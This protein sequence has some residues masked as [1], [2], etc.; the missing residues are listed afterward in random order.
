M[1]AKDLMFRLYKVFREI[2]MMSDKFEASS[3]SWKLIGRYWSWNE[4]VKTIIRVT[5]IL[6]SLM[7]C[8]FSASNALRAESKSIDRKL[9]YCVEVEVNLN[10]YRIMKDPKELFYELLVTRSFISVNKA[11]PSLLD[12]WYFSPNGKKLRAKIAGSALWND[13]TKLSARDAAFAI[14]KGLTFRPLGKKIRVKGTEQINDPGWISKTYEGIKIVS[15]DIF[16][17]SFD[18]EIEN[19]TGVL[20][21]A[22]SSNSRHN[23]LWPIKLKDFDSNKRIYDVI[24][25]FPLNA[26]RDGSIDLS[27]YGSTVSLVSKD[28]CQEA[29]FFAGKV[30]DDLVQN[31]Y[32]FRTSRYPQVGI[33]FINTSKDS[34]HSIEK[35]KEIAIWARQVVAKSL[36]GSLENSHFRKQEPGFVANLDWSELNKIPIKF[37]KK[38][39][40]TS[41]SFFDNTHPVR[42]TMERLTDE[43]GSKLIWINSNINDPAP[44]EVDVIIW[45]SRLEVD[46]QI[47][48]QDILAYPTI[49]QFLS[50]SPNTMASLDIILQKSAATIPVDNVTLQDLE[51]KALQEVSIVPITRVFKKVFSRK[52]LKFELAFTEQDEFTFIRSL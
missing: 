30:K 11:E 34:L 20:K 48:T 47:W 1:E 22:L 19:L 33:V 24:S 52:G 13:G 6:T 38:I 40:V 35:R 41:S 50:R 29:D 49:R 45:F 36:E 21:E 2:S 25:K 51:Q 7:F 23:R 12:S 37:P 4:Y 32:N 27:V 17:L 10:P 39:V 18:S 42:T 16:E 26:N 9:T 31:I 46:R 3:Q 5:T 8:L 15:D 43:L 44:P 14:A 28:K